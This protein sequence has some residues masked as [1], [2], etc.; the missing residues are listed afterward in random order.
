MHLHRYQLPQME[1][2]LS[3]IIVLVLAWLVGKLMA[4]RSR[5][6]GVNNRIPEF[7]RSFTYVLC[8]VVTLGLGVGTVF[9][10]LTS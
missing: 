6:R 3:I 2:L 4:R 1:Y 7:W 10:A 5:A 9:M 8:A